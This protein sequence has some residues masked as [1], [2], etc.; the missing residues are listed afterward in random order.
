MPIPTS[1]SVLESAVIAAPLSAVWH[2]IKLQDFSSF[3]RALKSSEV[4]T[5][6]SVNDEVDV[7]KWT[8]TDGMVLEVKMEEHSSIEHYITYSVISAAPKMEYSSVVSTVRCFPVTSGEHEGH[9]FVQ[10]SGNFSSDA[11]ADVI[12][13]AKYKRRE[14]LADLAAAVTKK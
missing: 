10:W 8:F 14:A 13:D 3:W 12:E 6:A 4:A 11:S 7:V 5:G 2:L 9:T 1:M